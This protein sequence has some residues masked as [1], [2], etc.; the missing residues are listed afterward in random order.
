MLQFPGTLSECRPREG[1]ELYLHAIE[2]L[3]VY[4]KPHVSNNRKLAFYNLLHQS[5]GYAILSAKMMPKVG[6]F[7]FL[8]E[9]CRLQAPTKHK[10]MDDVRTGHTLGTELLCSHFI[11]LS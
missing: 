6:M 4:P 2:Q 10:A 1:I 9:H 5:E 11:I 3:P 7:T 8:Q